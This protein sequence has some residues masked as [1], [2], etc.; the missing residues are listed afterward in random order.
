MSNFIPPENPCN[1]PTCICCRG[2]KAVEDWE[3]DNGVVHEVIHINHEELE[4]VREELNTGSWAAAIYEMHRRICLEEGDTV[5]AG[6]YAE[7]SK[8]AQEYYLNRLADGEGF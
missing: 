2:L 6:F 7:E 5:K 8:K 3:E 4:A 1:N